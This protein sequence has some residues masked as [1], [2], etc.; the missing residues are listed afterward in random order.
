MH[1]K[2]FFSELNEY[3]TAVLA[4]DPIDCQAGYTDGDHVT[5]LLDQ[6]GG[7]DIR[8]VELNAAFAERIETPE[9]A[10]HVLAYM[11]DLAAGIIQFNLFEASELPD[12]VLES[13][14]KVL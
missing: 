13:I 5:W 4:G 6:F 8:M 10:T 11:R 12:E 3:F 1:P 2:R 9:Q 14:A 7:D